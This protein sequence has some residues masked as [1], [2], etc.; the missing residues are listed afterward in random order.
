MEEIKL[1]IITVI[2]ICTAI[3][4]LSAILL[5]KRKIDLTHSYLV[6]IFIT[7]PF[8]VHNYLIGEYAQM[9]LFLIYTIISVQGFYS[10][11]KKI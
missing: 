4:I 9:T 3:K 5:S 2:W 7:P 11:R 10:W 8:I 1:E 6:T